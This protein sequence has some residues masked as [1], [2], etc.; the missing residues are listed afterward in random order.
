[1]AAQRAMILVRMINIIKDKLTC[2]EC[3]CPPDLNLEDQDWPLYKCWV[4]HSLCM[5]CHMQK[6]DGGICH[7]QLTS[8]RSGTERWCRETRIAVDRESQDQLTKLYGCVEELEDLGVLYVCQHCSLI[9]NQ[10]QF[11][12][13]TA[14]DHSLGKHGLMGQAADH[15]KLL[16]AYEV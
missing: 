4:G 1:M 9:I 10:Q 3:Q 13:G 11:C 7:V 15:F 8:T 2:Q 6:P 5:P 16:D 12:D 14:S